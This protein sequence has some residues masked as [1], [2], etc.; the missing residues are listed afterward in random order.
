MFHELLEA[1][2]GFAMFHAFGFRAHF[3]KTDP[4]LP[5]SAASAAFALVFKNI[6]RMDELPDDLEI[7]EPGNAQKDGPVGVTGMSGARDRL[8]AAHAL[9]RR[10]LA[11]GQ[12]EKAQDDE[13]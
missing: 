10:R 4:S 9:Q 11:G 8:H 13:Q 1:F 3:R 7:D 6:G 5:L 2:H 12:E